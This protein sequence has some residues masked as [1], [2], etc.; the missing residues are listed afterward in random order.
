MHHACPVPFGDM[1]QNAY[2]IGIESIG[3]R[4]VVLGGINGSICCAINDD[5]DGFVSNQLFN[6]ALVG[7]VESDDVFTSHVSIDGI[8]TLV[9]GQH[10]THLMAQLAISA[11]NK[12][13]SGFIH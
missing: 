10:V 13:I 8:E 7:D 4:L 5:A 6:C 9:H 3:K 2:S 1:S 12:Y 11:C